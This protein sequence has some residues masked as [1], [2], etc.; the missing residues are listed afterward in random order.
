[1]KNMDIIWKYLSADRTTAIGFGLLAL[2]VS[3]FGLTTN[4]YQIDFDIFT[5]VFFANYGFTILYL[6]IVMVANKSDYGKV[7]RFRHFTRNVILLQLFNISA[8]ALNRTLSVFHESVNWLVILLVVT[9]TILVLH[10]ILKNYSLSLF[11]HLVVTISTIAFLFHLYE[12]IYMGIL[13]PVMLVSFWFFGISL[14]VLVPIFFCFQF[15]IILYRCLKSSSTFRTTAIASLVVALTFIISFSYHYQRANTIISSG[16]HKH[17]EPYNDQHLP[18][19]V[20][21][22]Q[23]LPKNWITERLLNT[24][25]IYADGNSAFSSLGFRFNSKRKHDPLVVMASLFTFDPYL[26]TPDK[27]KILQSLYDQRHQTARK[28]WSG[29]NL[30]TT[31]IVTNV[32]LFP[33]YRLSYTEKTFKIHNSRMGRW[34]RTQEALYTFYLPEGAVVTS[35]SLWVN[36]QEEPAYLTTKSKADSAYTT[37][38][39]RERRD[40]LLL[41][42][43]EGNRVTVRVF[44]CTF[45]ED[46]IFK[47]GV[48]APLRFQ[49]EKL[50]YKNIDFQGPY[51]NEARESIQVLTAQD[52]NQFD[53]SIWLKSNDI[54]YHYKGK[55][56]SDWSIAFEA[57]PLAEDVFAFNGRSF[58]LTALEDATTSF[59]PTAVYLDIN[60]AWR[61]KE[62]ESLWLSLKDEAT[63]WVYANHRFKQLTASNRKD[64][65]KQLQKEN[66]SLFPF[67][68]MPETTQSLV[69]TKYSQLTPTLADLKH[70]TFFEASSDFF[71]TNATPIRVYNIGEENISPYLQT[72]KTYRCIQL[73]TIQFE[74]ML[75]A[76]ETAQFPVDQE[77][78]PNI[79]ANHYGDFQIREVPNQT[80]AA[81][82]APDHLMRLF[83][84]N[85]ILKAIGASKFSEE[86]ALEQSLIA[87]AQQA[88]VVT[89]I[90]SLIVLETQA[91]YDRFDIKKSKNSLENAAITDSGAV[92]E[93]HEW[94]LILVVFSVLF[95]LYFIRG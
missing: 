57:V 32:Q 33:S 13:Y 37:I 41:H 94:V 23:K 27:L 29:D 36:G 1:M 58:Q 84:Y 87:E 49:A 52:L 5:G 92:P 59:K 74:P 48:T 71:K 53:A 20:T 12:A 30:S 38:V 22:S 7:F 80:K 11:N 31:D 54:G 44:P 24:G 19:W 4:N 68:K 62:L 76:I 10:A 64:L 88:H 55:Y 67:Y 73:E 51:W 82:K 72:L 89:P 45:A 91:D 66:F 69:I 95:Y 65:F 2:S 86:N 50:Q 60:S 18:E 9:N 77:W 3:I 90:S 40:P 70:T 63:L 39:G 34:N 46:R 42:W 25:V 78:K 56:K 14:H 81:S 21:V 6:I 15:G 85:R 79:I 26:P 16:F 61:K 8:Y 28:L 93:P 43:Q 75:E 83:T 35:A 47:I 17:N